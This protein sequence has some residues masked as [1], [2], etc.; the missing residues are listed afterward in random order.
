MGQ[1]VEAIQALARGQEEMC[2]ANLRVVAANPVIM[3]IPMNPLEGVGTPVDAFFTTRADSVYDSFGPSSADLERSFHMMEDKLKA[4][5]GLNTFGLDAADM[6]LVQGVNIP[7]KFKVPNFEKYQGITYPKTH[8]RAFCRKMAAYSDDEKL[9]MHFFQDSLSGASL[10]WYIQLERTHIRTWRELAE[11][12]LKHYQYNPD[13]APNRTQL[14][15]LAQKPEES[16]KEYAQCWRDLAAR[17]QP[18]LLEKELVGMFMDTLQGPHIDRMI[19]S[20]ASGFSDLVTAGERIDNFLKI[21]NIQDIAAAA[22]VAK[23]SHSGPPKK[24]EGETNAA[25]I[26]KREA[27]A[28]QMP[29]YS[30]AAIT[31]NSYQQSTYAI[32][33]GPPAVQYQQPYAP[34][35]PFASQ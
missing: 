16:F 25:R 29:Y 32:P 12:F 4:I 24:K 20:A 6:C 23:K 3:I 15:S 2:Q 7:H 5:E 27:E 13:M 21:G 19:E 9:L 35:R 33:T 18:P 22:S 34:Q 1:L 30:V 28:Y 31:L 14:Q 10:E 11:A 17:V 26:A 8:I